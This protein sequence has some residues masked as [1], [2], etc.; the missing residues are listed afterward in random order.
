[1]EPMTESLETAEQELV[2][3]FA[4]LEQWDDRYEHIIA[5]GRALPPYPEELR[6]GAH[7]VLGCQSRV[8]LAARCE[9]GR[10]YFD[11]D[12]DALITKGLVALLVDLYSGRTPEVIRSGS[13]DFL[14]EIGLATHLT[15]SRVNGLQSMYRRIQEHAAQAAG[16]GV[17][18][19]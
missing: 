18:C 15:P 8:W 5:L 7:E 9:D 2:E 3:D 11:A 6:T 12:S 4:L 10:L 19:A 16:E 1:M 17:P 13:L 14:R